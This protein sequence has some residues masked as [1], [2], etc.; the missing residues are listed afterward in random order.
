MSN[1]LIVI[2]GPIS[3]GK[4][5]LLDSLP[6]VQVSE[7]DGN[8]DLQMLLLEK[9]YDKGRVHAEVIES[10]FLI[11]RSN[12]YREF[13]KEI[14]TCVLDRSIFESLWFAKGNMT[15]K[16]YDHFENLWESE[17]NSLI[18]EF[19][20][21]KMYIL[22]TMNWDTFKNRLFSRGRDVEVIN[23]QENEKFFKKHI[24]EYEEHMTWVF[25]KFDINYKK[26]KTDDLNQEEVL[27]EALE[28]IGGYNG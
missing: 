7:L 25:E 23:F 17:I 24:A 4:S 6:Y 26:I 16:S 13:A 5:T 9:T 22:L 20:K 19:G 2:G 14:N 3:V 21:P 15:Q 1:N 8:D 11:N 27:K 18:E 28:I 12:K 10:Y